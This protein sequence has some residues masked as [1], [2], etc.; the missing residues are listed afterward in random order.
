MDISKLNPVLNKE[1]ILKTA[2]ARELEQ[3]PEDVLQRYQGYALTH[4][5]LGDTTQQV[6]NLQR[7]ITENKTCAVGTI[8]GPYGYGKTS[9]A[10]HLWNELRETKILAVPPFLWRNLSELMEAVFYWARFEFS[11][12]P[13]IFIE[14]LEQLYQQ[15]RQSS[16][17]DLVQRLGA[18]TVQDLIDKGQLTLEIKPEDVVNFF[19]RT[20]ELA[21]QAGYSGIAIFTDELQATLA[22]YR[23][24]RDQFFAH[25]FE[26]V[27]DILGLAGNWALIMT[28]DDDTEGMIYRLRQDLLQRLQRSALYFRVKDVYSRREYPAELWGEF[29]KRFSFNGSEVILSETLESIG[30][31]AARSDL[32]AGPRMVTNALALAIKNFSDKCQSYSPLNFVDDF[33]NGLM[34][35]DQRGKFVVSVNKALD[36]NEV[37]SSKD[38]Q[39]LVKFLAAYPMGCTEELLKK[40]G[41]FDEFYN[42]PPL[43]RRELIVQLSGGYILRYL[44]EEDI[45]PE[46]IEQRLTNEFVNRYAPGKT[47]AK[48]AT[49]GFLQQV[50][51]DSI[52][53]NREWK[54]LD[55][56]DILANK[57]NYQVKILDSL[58]FGRC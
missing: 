4:I 50:L 57:I 9:T 25:L 34:L 10:V 33:L 49:D 27:K 21:T 40:F 24:S 15:S 48:Y 31:V 26:I 37:K 11:L 5:P 35:F 1:S 39:Q 41:F 44:A 32:G 17:N 52:F 2:N 45:E 20:S 13:K 58:P 16:Y 42:F 19:S 36:N 29:E 8:V 47:Y 23:P 22:A 38:R 14:S 53:K 56:R 46:Q 7:V 12:G 43:A 51:I 28:I 54:L 30:Q 6:K 18:E 55:S 3:S